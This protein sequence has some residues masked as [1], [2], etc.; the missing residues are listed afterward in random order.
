MSNYRD[1]ASMS[2][3]AD[4]DFIDTGAEFEWN[5]RHDACTWESWSTYENS[6]PDSARALPAVSVKD[7]VYYRNDS[8]CQEGDVCYTRINSACC[9]DRYA[10]RDRY[11]LCLLRRPSQRDIGVWNYD[12]VTIDSR[13]EW[14]FEA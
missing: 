12:N 10:D 3:F 2:D 1:V 5:T 8:K 7:V 14:S 9:S 13:T 6:P 11:P 4:E